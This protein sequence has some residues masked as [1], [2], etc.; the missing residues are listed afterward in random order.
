VDGGGALLLSSDPASVAFDP[1]L[2]A[3]KGKKTTL[4]HTAAASGAV[5]VLLGRDGAPAAHAVSLSSKRKGKGK[6]S[7]T[8]T[9]PVT[10][11]SPSVQ[12]TFEGAAGGSIG[13]TV[14]VSPKTLPFEVI[15]LVV[16]GGEDLVLT[17]P[18]GFVVSPKGDKVTLSA[19]VLK[20]TAT[21][22]CT[23]VVDPQGTGTV[24]A[25]LAITLPTG[26]GTLKD[27]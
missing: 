1:L 4:T 20:L 12:F 3:A 13:G 17:H 8:Q 14:A 22:T 24:T 10:D 27:E 25:K 6:L 16:P 11:A 2:V 5:Y 23:L 7:L 19:K 15:S 21:G 26:K 9:A 18:D